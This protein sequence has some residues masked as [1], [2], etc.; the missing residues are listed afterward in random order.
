MTLPY[1]IAALVMNVFGTVELLV[2]YASLIFVS[3]FISIISELIIITVKLNYLL[4]NLLVFVVSYLMLII[5]LDYLRALSPLFLLYN[6]K[7][8][9]FNLINFALFIIV[10]ILLAWK[11]SSKDY[12]EE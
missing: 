5:S 1:V 9:T 4:T 3:I 10:F 7:T 12:L 11:M 8:P 6:D 2:Y